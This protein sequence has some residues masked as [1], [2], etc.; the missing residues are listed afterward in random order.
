MRHGTTMEETHRGIGGAE[1]VTGSKDVA[2]VKAD[3]HTA[4]ILDQVDD[5]GEI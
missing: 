3:T 4:L 2:S 1:I 5:F